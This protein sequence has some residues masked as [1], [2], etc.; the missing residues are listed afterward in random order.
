MK[1][2]IV[3]IL[4]LVSFGAYAASPQEICAINQIFASP[5]SGS[6]GPLACRAMVI[7]DLPATTGTGSVVLSTSPTLVTPALGTPS[8]GIVTNLTGT[9]AGVSIGGNAATAT[10]ATNLAGGAAGQIP[11][12]TASGVTGFSIVYYSAGNVGIGYNPSPWGG[13]FSAEDVGA[14]GAIFGH[15]GGASGVTFNLYNNGTNWIYKGNFSANTVYLNAQGIFFYTAPEGAPGTVATVTQQMTLLNNGHLLLN[16]T[17]DNG[18]DFSQINGS[19]SATNFINTGISTQ[20][21]VYSTTTNDRTIL[22]NATTAA[23]TVTLVTPVGNQGLIQTVKKID[24][25]VNVVTITPAAGTIDG[26]ASTTISTQYGAVTVQ[27]DG[28]NYWVLH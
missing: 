11:Y 15:N 21:A 10:T 19:A 6:A 28:T 1:K 26:A 17:T 23:F 24:A 5:A 22:A 20:A 7:G 9:A 25:S 27:S 4:V 16:T 14:Y 2:L 8:S 18:R 3:A 12:Q 13:V